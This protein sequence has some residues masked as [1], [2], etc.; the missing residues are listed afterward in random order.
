M[1]NDGK[2]D[3]VAS[4]Q[5][6]NSIVVV[7]NSPV[8]ATD[9]TITSFTPT[10][11][12]MGTTVTI[13]GTNFSA[14]PANNVVKFN[15]TVAT[16]TASTSTSITTTVPT[17]ATTGKITVTVASSTATS[18]GSFTVTCT[19]PAKPAITNE[20]SGDLT[21]IK[22][23]SS[24]APAGGTYQWYLNGTAITGATSQDYTATAPGTYTVR[25]TVAGGC[26]TTSDP[27]EI[28]ITSVE[29]PNAL[30]YAKPYPNPAADWLTLP[31][32]HWPGKKNI[33]I[34]QTTGKLSTTYDTVD[35]EIKIYVADYPAGMY[36]V[37][38]ST[39]DGSGVL[40]FIKQ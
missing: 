37:K 25:I 16:V 34:Y 15:G 26:K 24:V 20:S 10:S 4:I 29:Q 31:L 28:V 8:T 22:L 13:N 6:S 23:S 27:F 40:K 38:V 36:I 18:A 14:T 17:G 9:P 21:S 12:A 33:T 35:E 19:A 2:S 30:S 3:L 1:D 32:N 39:S 11:G 7:R 5:A